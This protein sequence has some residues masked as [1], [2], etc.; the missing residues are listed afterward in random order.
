MLASVSMGVD[1]GNKR[2]F[3]Y[4]RLHDSLVVATQL[5]SDARHRIYRSGLAVAGKVELSLSMAVTVEATEHPA[6]MRRA[7]RIS[8]HT[9]LTFAIFVPPP[10]QLPA[11]LVLGVLA[12]L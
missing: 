5:Q 9:S 11:P 12:Y 4:G 6:I 3:R 1:V 7:W 2:V 10:S 8:L